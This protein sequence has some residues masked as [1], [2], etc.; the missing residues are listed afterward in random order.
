[1]LGLL[2]TVVMNRSSKLTK[3]VEYNGHVID[4][5]HDGHIGDI[6]AIF[7]ASY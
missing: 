5:S 1:M 7:T 3:P 6:G 2:P 4:F